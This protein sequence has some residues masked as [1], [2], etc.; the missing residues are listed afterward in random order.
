MILLLF[1]GLSTNEPSA[2]GEDAAEYHVGQRVECKDEGDTDWKRG[3]VTSIDPLEVKPDYYAK[4]FKWHCVRAIVEVRPACLAHK[5]HGSQYASLSVDALGV[6]RNGHRIR[7][8]G[9]VLFFH[10]V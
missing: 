1:G 3:E 7:A 9:R 8:W 10:I 4:G 5:V 6:V 2:S